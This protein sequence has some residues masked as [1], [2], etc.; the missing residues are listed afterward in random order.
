LRTLRQVFFSPLKTFPGRTVLKI[1]Q[2]EYTPTM[3]DSIVFAGGSFRSGAKAARALGRL[4]RLDI[5]AAQV[6][7]ITQQIGAELLARRERDAALHQRRELPAENATPVEIA[8]VEVDG[9]RMQTRAAEQGRGVHER[10][11]KETKVAA[12]WKMSGPTFEVDPHPDPPRCFLDAQHVTQMVREIKRQCGESHER[13]ADS[14]EN[15][16][17]SHPAASD[18]THTQ[19]GDETAID[20]PSRE[21][22]WP[23]A[24]VFRT[25]VATLK[26]VFG[27]G[28]LVAAETQRRGFHDAARRVFLGDGDHKNWTVHKLHFPDFTPITDFVHPVTYLHHAAGAVTSSWAAQWEQYTSW[29]TDCWQGRVDNVIAELREWQARLGEPDK[30]TPDGDPR[31]IVATTLT[32]LSNNQP[33]MDYPRYRRE[34]LPVTSCLVESLIKEINQRVKGTDQFWNRPD[35]TEGEAILQVTATLLSDGDPLTGHVLS[36]PGSP[37]YRRSTAGRLATPDRPD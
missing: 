35:A 7:R 31:K 11:W 14:G 20:P 33:R 22:A 3:I 8:C 26:D 12:L 19:S 2:R 5:S 9:G 28:Q 32:Y 17:V 21:R 10:G 23:P 25:C 29:M 16:V 27:F 4:S 18:Q 24:R 15:P 6:L 30:T 34:G 13:D 37:Y 36:R 1:D